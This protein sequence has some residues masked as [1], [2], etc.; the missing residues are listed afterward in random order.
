MPDTSHF[1]KSDHS[2]TRKNKQCEALPIPTKSSFL[3]SPDSPVFW[4]ANLLNFTK[5][6]RWKHLRF[7][8][9][10]VWEALLLNLGAR[11][12]LSAWSQVLFCAKYDHLLGASTLHRLGNLGKMK[13]LLENLTKVKPNQSEESVCKQ[14][15]KIVALEFSSRIFLSLVF[16]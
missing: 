11:M 2:W 9:K 5:V 8:S 3:V 7:S 6:H 14:T 4:N 10:M 12:C 16:L 15:E 1:L 13:S